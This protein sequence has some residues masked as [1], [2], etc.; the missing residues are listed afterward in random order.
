MKNAIVSRSEINFEFQ[1]DF[2]LTWFSK[3]GIIKGI[4][5]VC[6][7]ITF[8]SKYIYELCIICPEPDNFFHFFYFGRT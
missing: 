2:R 5:K 1:L 6:K 3:Q 7:H 4:L 8:D